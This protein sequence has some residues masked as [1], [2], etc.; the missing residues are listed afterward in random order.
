MWRIVSR[1][2]V[3]CRIVRGLLP[4]VLLLGGWLLAGLEPG[5]L[6]PGE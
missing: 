1:G 6:L 5:G 3:T 2:I 4:K